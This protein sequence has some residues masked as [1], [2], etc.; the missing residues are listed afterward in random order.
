MMLYLLLAVAV[1]AIIFVA[2]VLSRPAHFR[3]TRS[4]TIGAPPEAVFGYVNDVHRFQEWSPWAKLD[5]SAA[6]IYEGPNAGPGA[7]FT[8]KGGMKVGSG[9]MTV[10]DSV[11]HREVHF[12]LDF[13]KPM[14][15]TNMVKF[16][17]E[18]E[19]D[20]TLISWSMSG[21]NN[22][23]AKAFNLFIDCD[24]MCGGQFEQGLANLNGVVKAPASKS[25]QDL[26]PTA[27]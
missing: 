2:L 11:P 3:V 1:V 15:A 25:P 14:V 19:G 5:P 12:Q 27:V 23:V 6:I 24:K 16:T 4:A 7:S 18:P 21:R 17:L 20:Q 10:V 22:F 26:A 13:L 8:W 9:K